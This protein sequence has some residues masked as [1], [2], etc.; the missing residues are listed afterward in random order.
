VKNYAPAGWS[1]SVRSILMLPQTGTRSL[2]QRVACSLFLLACIR[3]PRSKWDRV[4]RRYTHPDQ[5][6]WKLTNRV[7]AIVKL[8]LPDCGLDRRV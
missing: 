2:A 5:D 3:K 1:L 4:R 6:D 8:K 7:G